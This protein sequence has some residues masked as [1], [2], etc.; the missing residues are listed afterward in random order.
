[1]GGLRGKPVTG[2]RHDPFAGYGEWLF[3]RK[4]L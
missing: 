3:G 2:K 4:S 1:M